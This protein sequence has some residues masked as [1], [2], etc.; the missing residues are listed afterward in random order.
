MRSSSVR[1]FAA[2]LSPRLPMAVGGSDIEIRRIT[3]NGKELY[4][5][6]VSQVAPLFSSTRSLDQADLSWHI[7]V[8]PIDVGFQ[9][10]MT[11]T[12]NAYLAILIGIVVVLGF[13][14]YLIT[15]TVRGEL[16]VARMKLDF[17]STVSHEFRSPLTGIRQLGEMLSRKRYPTKTNVSSTL[18]S[19]STRATA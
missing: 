3:I 16:E 17:V 5:K 7:Q 10:A 2:Q 18:I 19:L 11:R 6:P 1:S 13:G 4:S 14:S 12:T 8:A 15:R 9:A